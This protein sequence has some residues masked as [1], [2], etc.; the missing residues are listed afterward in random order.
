MGHSTH[1]LIVSITDN[2]G[3][4]PPRTADSGEGRP[5][6]T[7]TRHK[8]NVVLVTQLSESLHNSTAMGEKTIGA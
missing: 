8:H 5:I 3:G 7:S 2:G 6:V 1:G 4:V